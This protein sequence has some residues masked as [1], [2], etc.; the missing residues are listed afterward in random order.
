[1]YDADAGCQ[2]AFRLANGIFAIAGPASP[3]SELTQ[4]F[5]A[6]HNLAHRLRLKFV[7]S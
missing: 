1:M 3:M 7:F 4:A 2:I 5:G 6:L